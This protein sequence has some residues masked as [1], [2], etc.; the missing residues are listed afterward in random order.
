MKLAPFSKPF[1]MDDVLYL[2]HDHGEIEDD[3]FLL[4][5]GDRKYNLYT[6]LPY[7]K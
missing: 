7:I 6:G 5:F 3:E 1:K 4:L 2:L